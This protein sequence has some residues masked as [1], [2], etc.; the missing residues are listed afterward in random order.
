MKAMKFYSKKMN[1]DSF[2]AMNE[3]IL[4]Q[5]QTTFRNLPSTDYKLEMK[6]KGLV[7]YRKVIFK[8][9]KIYALSYMCLKSF[10]D[11]DRMNTFFNSLDI[12]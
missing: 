1:E 7:E 6:D 12:Q 10:F 11:N 5:K 8:K 2:F 3:T 4:E 9:D